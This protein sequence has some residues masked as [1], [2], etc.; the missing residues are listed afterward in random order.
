MRVLTALL[1]G[2]LGV[3]PAVAADQAAVA[4][5]IELIRQH[6]N[7]QKQ[8]PRET[9]VLQRKK[10]GDSFGLLVYT[11][12]DE[13]QTMHLG[14]ESSITIGAKESGYELDTPCDTL[15]LTDL[16]ADGTVDAHHLKC[17]AWT[18][19]LKPFM[20]ANRQRLFDEQL[21]E[22]TRLLKSPSAAK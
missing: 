14:I 5:V 9:L 20:D 21:T 19:Q 15:R 1:L 11:D 3:S 18:P 10:D 4:K 6:P 12:S 7:V 13:T 17:V 16:N 22:A 2:F 8:P